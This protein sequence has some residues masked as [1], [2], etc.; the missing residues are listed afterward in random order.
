MSALILERPR[1]PDQEK[2]RP[3][4]W[5]RIRHLRIVIRVPTRDQLELSVA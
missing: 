1:F 5:M 2:G 4:V 3:K